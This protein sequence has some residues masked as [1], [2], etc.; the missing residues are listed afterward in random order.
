LFIRKA[1]MLGYTL[2]EL[3]RIFEEA[4]QG[5]SLCPAVR[6]IV[7]KRIKENRHR[8]E[9]LLQMQSRMEKAVV[10]WSKLPD[11]M[12]NGRSVCHLIESAESE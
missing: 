5:D 8:V 11:G 6:D 12:P 4:A 3:A 9:Q 1:Q 7:V 2:S 10:R